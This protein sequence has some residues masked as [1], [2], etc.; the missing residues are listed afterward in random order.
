[1]NSVNTT[2]NGRSLAAVVA[3]LKD[4]L[5][6]F[7]DTRL[8]MLLSELKEVTSAWKTALPMM[9]VGALLMA[10]GFLLFTGFLVAIIATAFGDNQYAVAIALI[11]VTSAYCLFG[12]MALLFGWRSVKE[13]GLR[14]N[15]TLRVLR[16]DQ[17][18]LRNEARTQL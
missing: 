10:T 12:G 17:L 4:E 15:R 14:P 5:K 6:D 16:E 2:Y 11:I 8:N 7:L 3:E 18:W 1:V 13:T 9:V